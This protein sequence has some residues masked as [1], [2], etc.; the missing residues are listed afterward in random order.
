MPEALWKA[1]ATDQK[2]DIERLNQNDNGNV[3]KLDG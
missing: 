2:G 1:L 3:G